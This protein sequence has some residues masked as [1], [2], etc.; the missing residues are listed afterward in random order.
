MIDSFTKI[1]KLNCSIS[2]E[3]NSYTINNSTDTVP[4]KLFH[5]Y[6]LKINSESNTTNYPSTI[7][8]RSKAGRI[9]ITN[10]NTFPIH[11]TINIGNSRFYISIAENQA[12]NFYLPE[13]A[14]SY[15]C[16]IGGTSLIKSLS[17]NTIDYKNQIPL[18]DADYIYKSLKQ[19][20][21]SSKL[22]NTLILPDISVFNIGTISK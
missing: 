14:Y 2:N 19:I 20:I 18:A 16:W 8:L 11:I 3:I 17:P 4:V 10:P 13:V 22:E 15:T 5:H 21:V 7:K 6:P 9:N 1:K 12:E